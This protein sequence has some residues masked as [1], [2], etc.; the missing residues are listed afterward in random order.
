PDPRPK[1]VPDY[2]FAPPEALT[3]RAGLNRFVWNLQWPH[4]DVLPYNFYGQH[5]DYIEYTLP[6][7][8]VAGGT[9]V[10]QPTGP[11]VVPG[12]YELAL[13]VD[14]KTFRQSLTVEFDPRVHVP[15]TDLEA[16]LDLAR[17][18][19]SWMN[20]SYR[21]YNSVAT[22]RAALAAIQKALATNSA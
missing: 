5:I 2:W 13:T 15:Q 8:A 3:T 22:L 1:N 17:Q 11:F 21:S 12:K 20:I 4:P 10:N 9:P 16:Q 18:M 14:G 19:D 6:D 7:H